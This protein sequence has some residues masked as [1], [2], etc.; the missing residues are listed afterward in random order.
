[1]QQ[2]QHILFMLFLPAFPIPV[3]PFQPPAILQSNV[4]SSSE[5]P[6]R[7]RWRY[8][9]PYFLVCQYDFIYFKLYIYF[10][11]NFLHDRFK[12]FISIAIP[13]QHASLMPIY[14]P[15]A[16]KFL[17]VSKIFIILY[18]RLPCYPA[19]PVIRYPHKIVNYSVPS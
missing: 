6:V 18:T 19:Y 15:R 5:L 16:A 11:L 8:N 2:Q 17:I 3:S 12:I 10:F 13:K 4:S 14:F 1:M 7:I 9:N